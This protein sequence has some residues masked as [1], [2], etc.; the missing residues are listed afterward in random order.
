MYGVEAPITK[1]QTATGVKDKVAQYWI[2]ILLK[3]ARVM[4]ADNPGRTAED[5]AKELETWLLEQPGD[6]VNPLLDIS[7]WLHG[8]RVP[9]LY[10]K[11]T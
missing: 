7:G 8:G 2:E 5:I 3:K 10:S 6:K 9:N 1:L 4:K 11:P